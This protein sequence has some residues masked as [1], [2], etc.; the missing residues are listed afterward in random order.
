MVNFRPIFFITGVLLI[1]LSI[2]MTIP[3]IADLYYSNDDWKSF[4]ASAFFTC[5]IGG[6]MVL[7]NS[8]RIKNFNIKQAFVLTAFTWL[9]LVVFSSLPFKFARL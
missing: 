8:G 2:S 7:S 4:L 9:I 5:F 1:V 3:A 6:A